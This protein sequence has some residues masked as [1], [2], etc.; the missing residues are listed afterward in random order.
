M[1]DPNWFVYFTVRRRGHV[2]VPM[3]RTI[4]GCARDRAPS[5][6]RAVVSRWLS[7]ERKAG[8]RWQLVSDV[9]IQPAPEQLNRAD[10]PRTW[11]SFGTQRR[12]QA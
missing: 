5:R 6:A 7:N 3:V 1:A 12:G 10:D 9:D 2:D 8:R 11:P 4:I